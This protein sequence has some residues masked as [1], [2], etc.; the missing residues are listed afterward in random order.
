MEK[1]VENNKVEYPLFG[2][3]AYL[4]IARILGSALPYY[5]SVDACCD[6]IQLHG[7]IG[8]D[9]TIEIQDAMH[10][11]HDSTHHP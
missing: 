8:I 11:R 10:H 4:A 2:R 5:Q 6:I 9:A 1:G 7:G 3:V